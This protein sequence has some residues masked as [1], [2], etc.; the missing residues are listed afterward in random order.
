MIRVL[1]GPSRCSG[2][3]RSAQTCVLSNCTNAGG[4]VP[5]SSSGNRLDFH[6]LEWYQI[7]TVSSC[8]H[9]RILVEQW[10]NLTESICLLCFRGRFSRRRGPEAVIYIYIYI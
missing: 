7:L 8:E 3:G 10:L 5:Y 1:R 2:R 9:V 4:T 6:C